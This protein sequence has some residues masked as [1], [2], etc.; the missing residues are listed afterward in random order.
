MEGNIR[1]QKNNSVTNLNGI[2][3][4]LGFVSFFTDISSEMIIPLIPLFLVSEF[5]AS[6]TL[7]G[8]IEGIADATS[9]IMKG[10]S[11]FISDKIEHKRNLI[12][13]GYGLSSFSKPIIALATGA[14]IV[15]GARFSDKI[16]KGIRTSPRDH[17]VSNASTKENRGLAF[18]FHRAMDTFGALI[19]SSIALL[20]LVL[21]FDVE[22]IYR[23]LFILAFIPAL[24]GVFFIFLIK[25]NSGQNVVKIGKSIDLKEYKLK[26]N[27]YLFLLVT[28]TL[29]F[30]QINVSFLVLKA[31][32]VFTQNTP[33][34]WNFNFGTLNGV[35]LT[36]V[37]YVFFNI[38]YAISSTYLGKLSDKYGRLNVLIVAIILLFIILQ[39]FSL[40]DIMAIPE[41]IILGWILLGFY[42][43][44]TTGVAKAYVADITP[45]EIR[46]KSYGIFNLSIGITVLSSAIIFGYLWDTLGTNFV[47]NLFSILCVIPFMGF[48][49]YRRFLNHSKINGIKI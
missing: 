19:G 16:G 8:L 45:K 20:T 49:F 39:L 47:F 1:K 25:E 36:L 7:V 12:A 4:I 21:F 31:E 22:N 3:I 14:F 24:L 5:G 33:S 35:I 43:A 34:W 18:G 29:Y 17:L 26:K 46:G 6:V 41:L 28:L 11:G 44:S 48:L 13:L 10:V 15:L 23:I 32:D 38:F 9:N 37:S 40:A 2:I 42:M 27:Y 30:V